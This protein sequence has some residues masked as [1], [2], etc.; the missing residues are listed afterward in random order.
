MTKKKSA[1][2]PVEA[3]VHQDKRANIPTADAQ[4]FMPPDAEEPKTLLY[5]RDASLDPQLV[6][7]GKDEQD[8]D[9]LEVVAPPIFIRVCSS[10]TFARLR[11][12][13]TPSRN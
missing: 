5:Q 4:D 12:P 7:K 10:R 11:R 9:A 13:A 3:T 8:S 2:T 1:S 6:W